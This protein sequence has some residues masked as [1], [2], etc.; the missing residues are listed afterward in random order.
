MKNVLKMLILCL[1]VISII[2]GCQMS[3]VKVARLHQPRPISEEAAIVLPEPLELSEIP[4]VEEMLPL[5]KQ[6][7][8]SGLTADACSYWNLPTN[9]KNNL[10][11]ASK[12]PD[13]YQSG[14]DHG[15]NQQWSHAY[16]Y[17]SLGFWIWG[18]ADDDFYDNLNQDGGELESP[19]GYNDRSAKYYYDRNDQYNGDWYLGYAAHYIEDVSLILHA[20]DPTVDMLIHH[21]D[22]EAWIANNWTSGHNFA[23]T[24]AAD[25]YYYIVS[26]PKASIRN[27]AKNCSYWTS[28]L[29]ET[30]W[31]N[32]EASGFPTGTGIGN[33]SLVA[34]TKTMLIRAARYTRGT[35]KYTLD[36]YNQW[37]NEY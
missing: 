24:V 9:R 31:D 20:S 13:T 34:N 4:Y 25:Q 12:M 2:S 22:F 28:D 15:F 19:E 27:A 6:S 29:G 32:Y 3:D 10:A 35:I 18:D 7:T 21:F 33:S 26:D 30:V 8:H 5:W 1:L 17:T 23:A 36:K 11:A 16:L 37:G 14:L